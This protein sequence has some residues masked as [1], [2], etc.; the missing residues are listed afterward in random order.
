MTNNIM[1][2]RIY[3]ILLLSVIALFSSCKKEIAQTSISNSS[4]IDLTDVDYKVIGKQ[5]YYYEDKSAQLSFD[6]ISDASFAENF[7]HSTNESPSFGFT[8]SVYWVKFD[9]RN[10]TVNTKEYW[11]TCG[12]PLINYIDL[13]LPNG[14]IIKAGSKLEFAQRD[15][16]YRDNVFRLLVEGDTVYTYYM[17]FETQSSM[18]FPLVLQ[19]PLSFTEKINTELLAWGLYFGIVLGMVLYNF[20]LFFSIRNMNYF[21]YVIYVF[22]YGIF[23][24]S[25]RGLSFEYLW[26]ESIWWANN[27]IPIFMGIT[28]AF[29]LQFT[30]SFLNT[31]EGFP[32]FNLVLNIFK[33][34]NVVIVA[35]VF[36]VPYKYAIQLA[37]ISVMF[38]SMLIIFSGAYR[39]L[40]GYKAAKFFFIAWFAFII[41]IVIYT[42]KTFGVFP[43]SNITENAMTVGSALEIILLSFALADSYKILKHENELTQ[44]ELLHLQKQTN[45]QLEEQVRQ[46]TQQIEQ[47]NVEM[48]VAYDKLESNKQKLTTIL[49]TAS[50]GIGLTDIRG[51]ITYANPELCK[52][53]NYSL[54]EIS[55]LSFFN[56]MLPDEYE[57]NAQAMKSMIESDL[58]TYMRQN[59]FIRKDGSTFWAKYSVSVN[60]NL[61][62]NVMDIVGV[63][64]DI[65]KLKKNELAIKE[66]HRHIT[67]SINYAKRIQSAI[68][69]QP[70]SIGERLSEHFVLFKPRD[71][72][73][74]D[75]FWFKCVQEH[76]VIVAADCTG[77]GVPGAFMS[78]LGI[79]FLN[80][81]ILQKEIQKPSQLLDSLREKVKTAL[82]QTGDRNEQQDG[83]DISVCFLNTRTKKLQFAGANSPLYIIRDSNKLNGLSEIERRASITER[84]GYSLIQIKPD[85]QPIGV[86]RREKP[87]TNVEITV[88]E[89]D[90]LYLFSD[91]FVDQFGG[92]Q[93]RKYMSKNFKQLLLNNCEKPMAEQ[94]KVLDNVITSWSG[95]DCKQ[96]DDILV[97]GIRV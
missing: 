16:Q 1:G 76:V 86:F 89:N 25:L 49:E 23:Q 51:Q 70:I 61:Q 56:F 91:G 33:W 15:I 7:I 43:A 44:L 29:A 93:K 30:Q 59:L 8:N 45:E 83:M 13:Y 52:M 64:T 41:G 27:N 50:E 34:F 9:L 37:T 77:H 6:E 55:K 63:V 97:I 10:H 28:A 71:I 75:F 92:E 87:F 42:L 58:D 18:Q 35:L 69:P 4:A 84:N 54:E 40:Q 24:F 17:R 12:Y 38:S 14:E 74:G 5:I 73:S 65:D 90:S 68:L 46:R 82:K 79:A 20:F 66:A 21:Y 2:V 57:K 39:Y 36:L 94:N 88:Q 31:K 62:G 85:K 72:V 60:R 67:G 53:L 78:M 19:T 32:K 81:I 95:N 11:L 47:Q 3:F 48:V 80:E 96:I 22:A 26:G